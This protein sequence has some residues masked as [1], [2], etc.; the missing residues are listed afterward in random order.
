[1]FVYIIFVHS[2][3]CTFAGKK[4]LNPPQYFFHHP[5]VFSIFLELG[6]LYN[7]WNGYPGSSQNE[8]ERACA[9][10]KGRMQISR[11]GAGGR[12]IIASLQG[13]VLLVGPG[14]CRLPGETLAH[15][16]RLSRLPKSHLSTGDP[17]NLLPLGVRVAFILIW[18]WKCSPHSAKTS[19]LLDPELFISVFSCSSLQFAKPFLFP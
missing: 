4:K 13:R 16:P 6:K 2:I 11:V 8:G 15:S 7:H 1:M 9:A 3:T 12:R 5:Y 17:P 14:F 19:A 10:D 18:V